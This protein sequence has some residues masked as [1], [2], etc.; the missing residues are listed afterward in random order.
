MAVLSPWA[1]AAAFKTVG[2]DLDGWA[3]HGQLHGIAAHRSG[4]VGNGQGSDPWADE[5]LDF[6]HGGT[7]NFHATHRP[8]VSDDAA[9]GIEGIGAVESKEFRP[10]AVAVRLRPVRPGVGHG[11]KIARRSG[12]ADVVQVPVVVHCAHPG[13]EGGVDLAEGEESGK[14]DF[15]VMV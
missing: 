1:E 2:E 5:N 12:Q 6:E 3:V 4:I 14:V 7:A 13:V 15:I 8:T 10:V 9:V 11:R